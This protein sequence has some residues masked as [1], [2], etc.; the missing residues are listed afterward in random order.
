[1]IRFRRSVNTVPTEKLI[2][3]RSLAK[4]QNT[5]AVGMKYKHLEV[6]YSL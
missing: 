6:R 1:M 4:E 3:N 2:H 5:L